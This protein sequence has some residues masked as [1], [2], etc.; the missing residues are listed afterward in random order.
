MTDMKTYLLWL[1]LST[2]MAIITGWI[3]KNNSGKHWLAWIA[4]PI[5]IPLFFIVALYFR[6]RNGLSMMVFYK[7]VRDSLF[8]YK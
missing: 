4:L 6:I 7:F 3:S 1:A 5:W 2:F 8:G